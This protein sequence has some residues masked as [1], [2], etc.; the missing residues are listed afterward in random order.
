MD[1]KTDIHQLDSYIKVTS[2]S[3]IVILL[4]AGILFISVLVWFFF[5]NVNDTAYLRGVIFPSQGSTAVN[6][7]NDGTVR[8]IFVHK[9]DAV[10]E[11]QQLALVSIDGAYSMVSA[12]CDGVVLSYIGEGGRF[13]PFEG[14]VSLLTQGSSEIVSS[15]VALADFKASRDMKPGQ[16]AQV[17]PSYDSRERIGYIKGTVTNVV[18]YPIS[19]SEAE[20][21]FENKSIVDEIYPESGAVFFVGIDLEKD[22]ANPEALNW[23]FSSNEDLDTGVGT[24]CDIQVIVKSRSMFKYLVENVEK[25]RRSVDLWL[26]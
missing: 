24:Y 18:P 17:T 25:K 10:V 7:P 4:A 6:L 9:G 16:K 14:I 1:N 15:V 13:E 3:Q 21:F 19:R 26:E 12:P 23:S 20:D 8:T 11:G 5:G 22:P 2:P